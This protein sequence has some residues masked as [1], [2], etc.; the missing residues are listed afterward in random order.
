M[1]ETNRG[2]QFEAQIRK[3]F[4]KVSGVSV[5]RLYDPM[6]GYVGVAN[7]CDFIVYK[8]PFQYY[9]ECKSCHGASLPFSNITEHQWKGLLEKS[10][11]LGVKAAVIIWF[12]DKDIT[13]YVPIQVLQSLKE[14][15]FKSIK[16]IE[17]PAFK[18]CKTV[19]GKK[20]KILYDYDVRSLLNG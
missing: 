8:Y 5:D 10:K 1:T 18:D 4:E 15:G 2:K 19:N 12:I 20:R 3:A 16:A 11:I 14:N 13:A 6:G 9:I 7:I 17:A